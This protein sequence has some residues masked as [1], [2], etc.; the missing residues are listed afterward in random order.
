MLRQLLLC[1]LLL[2]LTSVTLAQTTAEPPAPKPGEAVVKV[3]SIA[4]P[5]FKDKKYADLL[6]IVERALMLARSNGDVVG[7]AQS[8]QTKAQVLQSLNRTDQAVAAWRETAATWKRADDGPGEINALAQAALLLWPSKP[9]EGRVWLQEAL[10]VGKSEQKRPLAAATAFHRIGGAYYSNS[11][12]DE[13]QRFWMAALTIREKLIPDSL[14]VAK[15]LNNLGNVAYD[16]GELKL[17][18]NYY[19]RSLAIKTKLASDSLDVAASLNNLGNVAEDRGDL[20]TAED[21][22]RRSLAIKEKKVPNTLD[23]AASL[24]NLGIMAHD[25]GDLEAAEDYHRRALAI[26]EKLVPNSLEVA[27]SLN[28]LGV[29]ARERG[30][31]KSAED[32]YLRSLTIKEKQDHNSLDVAASLNNLGNVAEDRDDLKSAEEYH[33][34][35]LAIREKLVPNSL[36]VATSLDNLGNV[37]QER[38]DLKSAKD[39]YQRTLAIREKLAPNSLE[40]V[41]SLYNQAAVTL[42]RAP[43]TALPLAQHA[44]SLV[45]QQSALL[46]GGEARQAFQ[47]AYADCA[48]AL[49]DCQVALHQPQ[50]AFL[51]LEQSRAQALLQMLNDRR[52]LSTPQ[53]ASL[54]DT[55]RV[56]IRT[57]DQA[58]AVVF[59]A[60]SAEEHARLQL[61]AAQENRAASIKI[62]RLKTSL[63]EAH[64]Q[65]LQAEQEYTRQRVATEAA[66][67]AI[68]RVTPRAFPPELSLAQLQQSLPAE[69]LSLAFSVGKERSSLFLVRQNHPVQVITLSLTQRAL[70]EKVQNLRQMLTDPNSGLASLNRQSHAL[71]ALLFPPAAQKQLVQS[72]HL[73]ILPDGPLWQLPFAALVTTSGPAPHYLGVDKPLTVVQSLS[74]FAR[75][76]QEPRQHTPGQP[77]NALVVGDPVFV[78]SARTAATSPA[79]G[80]TSPVT[81]INIGTAQ[82]QKTA[83]PTQIASATLPVSHG[84]RGFLWNQN[85]PPPPLPHTRDEAIEIANLYNTQ[86]LLA[87]DATEA[88]VRARLASADI[89]H[90]ATHGYLN[91]RVPMASGVLL[92]SP[93]QEPVS[94]ETD[95]DG[96]LQAWE[97]WH[98]KLKADLVV[99]SACETGLGRHVAGEGIIG[100]SRALQYAGCRSVIA[101]QWKV[102]DKSTARLMVLLHEGL[103]AGLSK[104][105]AL[106]RAM[107]QVAA[108]SRTRH[109]YY[110]APFFL[111]GDNE[112]KL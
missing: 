75:T 49:I 88:N 15:S 25:H 52:L 31:L 57:Q 66:W 22:Y 32:Y 97:I 56:A 80:Q 45:R 94:G 59:E 83:P 71:F 8:L 86:P 106:R 111:I 100:L 77:L 4:E 33:R 51:T 104:D 63:D 16:R 26:R 48:L 65:F 30:E 5:L 18:E 27:A 60:S 55:Y 11:L 82:S 98:L 76:R 58:L 44:W 102:E 107:K 13:A 89:I 3:L 39:Y 67:S 42:H 103:K 96:A 29:V 109:P 79:N 92:T 10:E 101:S 74:L 14:E 35:A 23:V 105:E 20:E 108:E 112:N 36:E 95:N 87:A 24:N 7:E 19:R 110:W 21:F 68:T 6:P 17:A 99:L 70:E 50:A 69:I 90:L 1:L 61:A 64:T 12:L 72:S 40:I 62:A 91:P 53:T 46:A 47:Q 81:K 93:E 84:E 9:A 41:S 78:R 85:S 37:A 38:G 73:L 28:N 2:C 54:W 43:G 34:R